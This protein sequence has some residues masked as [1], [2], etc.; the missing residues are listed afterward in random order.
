MSIIS[1]AKKV[2]GKD[3]PELGRYYGRIELWNSV[4]ANRPP[5]ARVKKSGLFSSGDREMSRLGAAKIIADEF[6]RLTFSEKINI[7]AAEPY[8]GYVSE[9]LDE[10][11]FRK[12]MPE[13]FSTAYALGG[14]IIK[15][16]AENGRPHI[17]YVDADMF[18]PL[19][20][21]EREIFSG[22]FESRMFRNGHFYTLFEKY[23]PNE[24]GGYSA[25]H[26][27][28]RSD[29]KTSVG[30]ECPLAELFPYLPE[31]VGYDLPV[32]MFRYF[33]PAVSNNID[34]YSP[35]GVSVFDGTL[36]VL[37][38]LDIAFD[39][40]TRE[41]I[42]GKK[43]IIVPSSCIR[44]IIDVD[45]GQPKRYFDADDE[46]YVA[47]KCDDERELKISDNTVELRVEE[48][49]SA[50]N[51]LLDLLCF[52]TGLSAGTFSFDRS[53][54]GIKTAAEIISS[55]NKTA[56]TAESNK[57]LAAEFIAET[58]KSI[59]SLGVALGDLPPADDYGI[60]VTMPDGIIV[61]DN[62]KI[63]NNIKLVAAGLRSR[64]SAIADICRCDAAGANKELALISE[65][66][67]YGDDISSVSK[68]KTIS[69][70]QTQ[71]ALSAITKYRSGD[72]TLRQAAEII[73][74]AM[75]ISLE[76]A[77]RLAGEQNG[78]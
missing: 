8:I 9:V 33:R 35:L 34:R 61:D 31:K 28:F 51:A 54:S 21:N 41:F 67:K 14:G 47:L 29:R 58:V 23:F 44:T 38:A 17:N 70:V 40:F 56:R 72:L 22:V 6:S 73:S 48:H 5:W 26:R 71:S 69:G 49:I 52:Q 18:I 32:P 7:S 27:L 68:S 63:E 19:S 57:N 37:K 65:E 66:N 43:R 13:F 24:N 11:G 3:V 2:Y 10:N 1:D 12:H 25:E 42:L 55:D 16:Y 30:E 36:D 62:T 53:R 46:A 15:I 59:I 39:S 45:S 60:S 64:T 77:G 50:I 4:F 78:T 75:G 76:E 74:A 20:W